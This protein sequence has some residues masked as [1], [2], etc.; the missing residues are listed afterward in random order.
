MTS[1]W[2]ALSS[3]DRRCITVSSAPWTAQ[4]MLD[5]MGPS[6]SSPSHRIR[7]YTTHTRGPFT[8]STGRHMGGAS[9]PCLRKVCSRLIRALSTSI[10]SELTWAVARSSPGDEAILL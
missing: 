5:C 8:F 2:P 10:S 6:S 3:E 4:D 1:A 9:W 7:S